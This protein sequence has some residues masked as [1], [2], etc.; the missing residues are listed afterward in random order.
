MSFSVTLGLA[1]AVAT[2]LGSVA[3]FLYKFKVARQA[4]PVNL[5]PIHS[6][7]VLFGSPLYTLGIILGL[8]SWGVHVGA[9]GL[10]P[11]SLVQS[12]IAGG[13]VLLTFVADRLFGISVS[14]R[15]LTGSCWR[16][17]A[18]LSWPRR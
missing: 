16:R 4:P 18:W 15:E 8:A 9:L 12:V 1:L 11:I 14:R 17:P 3:G 10:A 13:L 6:S 2:A 5:R 7:V